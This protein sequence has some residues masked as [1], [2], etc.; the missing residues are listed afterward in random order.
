MRLHGDLDPAIAFDPVPPQ[1]QELI[2]QLSTVTTDFAELLEE[3]EQAYRMLE[4]AHR[5]TLLRLTIAAE[6]RDDD[7]GVHLVRMGKLSGLLARIIGWPQDKAKMLEDAAPMHDVG[8]IGI[9]DAVLKKAGSLTPDEWSIMRQHPELGAKI[10]G[11]S[12][13]PVLDMAAEIA[14]CH[15]EKYDGTG[16][17]RGLVGDAIPL[18][19]RIVSLMDYFDALTM[20]R[21]YRKAFPD[22]EVLTMIAEQS[23][24]HFD[25]DLTR[26]FLERAD[27]FIRMRDDIN[28]NASSADSIHDR[29]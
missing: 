12:G 1:T 15:H 25:P 16:Y 6:F 7:T 29:I 28:A 21:V 24:R 17:P 19:A 9:P 8:K 13:V 10:L 2:D 27:D 20:D 3:R 4:L 5:Q 26:I 23:G 11:S 18:T 22:A 14:Y